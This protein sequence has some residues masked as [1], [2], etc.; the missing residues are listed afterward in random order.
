MALM[1][2]F[3]LSAQQER[4]WSLQA[5]SSEPFCSECHFLVEGPLDTARLKDSVRAVIG[6]HEI[7]RTVFRRQP[8]LKL[9]FQVI[10]TEAAFI[11]RDLDLSGME[12]GAAVDHMHGALMGARKDL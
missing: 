1:N 9:P 4:I 8:G 11:W 10:E 2:A 12:S 7:L 3:R 6:A 5:D